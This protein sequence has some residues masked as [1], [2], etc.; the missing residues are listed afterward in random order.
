MNTYQ[1]KFN[2]WTQYANQTLNWFSTD[3][4]KLYQYN[5]INN[6]ELLNKYGYIENKIEYKF[7]SQ[8]FRCDE[9]SQK[10][11]VVFLGCSITQ[12]VGV[13]F[14]NTFAHLIANTLD[15]Q[16]WNLG[17]QSKSSDSAFRI[18]LEYINKLNIKM[19]ITFLPLKDRFELLTYDGSID[20]IPSKKYTESYVEEYYKL[21]NSIP[22]NAHINSLKNILAIKQLCLEKNIKFVDVSNDLGEI[23]IPKTLQPLGRDLIHPGP[24]NHYCRSQIILNK[25]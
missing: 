10:E 21:Y 20:F 14:E 7:N 24:A 12:G 25:I 15:L 8:G 16:C 17:Q 4:E 2:S 18:L 6:Y 9:F 3:S 11:S 5:L 22:E 13:S 1:T 19:V 23:S